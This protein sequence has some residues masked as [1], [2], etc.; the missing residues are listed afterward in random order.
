MRFRVQ[1]LALLSGLRIG[2]AMSCGVGRRHGS[3]PTLL[4][5]WHRPVATALIS[6]L[7]WESPFGVGAAQEMAKSQ[8]K[9]RLSSLQFHGA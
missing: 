4:W 1:S 9:K 3:D 8:K 7:A 6:P 5:L 2:V